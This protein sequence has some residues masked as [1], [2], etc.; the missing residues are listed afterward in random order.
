MARK[1]VKAAAPSRNPETVCADVASII[2]ANKAE[3]SAAETALASAKGRK[4]PAIIAALKGVEAINETSWVA[5][6][7]DTLAKA[8]TANGMADKSV[9]SE[10]SMLKVVFIGATNGYTPAPDH[11]SPR[12]FADFIREDLGNKGL[13]TPGGNS[14]K[15]A[16]H[17]KGSKTTAPTTKPGTPAGAATSLNDAQIARALFTKI[18]QNPTQDQLEMLVKMIRQNPAKFWTKI[19]ALSQGN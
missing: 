9:K 5:A 11:G 1:P 17:A 3:V 6:W 7:K 4:L 16:P 19:T 18:G 10:V 8:L 12:A 14:G 2:K 13:I 15:R